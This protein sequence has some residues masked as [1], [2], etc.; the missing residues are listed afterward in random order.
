MSGLYALLKEG[1]NMWKT[2][3]LAWA[4][5]ALAIL[6]SLAVSGFASDYA[7]AQSEHTSFLRISA[8]TP[9]PV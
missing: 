1:M 4:L 2:I 5:I 6:G 3:K 9:L 7:Y 8:G